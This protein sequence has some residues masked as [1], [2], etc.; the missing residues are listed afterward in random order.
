MKKISVLMAT[1]F[2]DMIGFAI[3]FPILPFYA[4]RFDAPEWMI[5]PLLASFSVMQLIASPLWGR[6]SD[7]FGRR[8]AI[9]LGLCTSAIAFLIF[10]FAVNLLMLFATRLVQGIGGGTTGVAQAYVGDS[11]DPKDRAKALGWL[12]AAT[13]AGV[14][15]GPAIGSYAFRLG[16]Q[17]PGL[18]ASGLCLLNVIF[19]WFWLPESTP[20][21]EEEDANSSAPPKERRAVKAMMLEVLFTP[22]GD[23]PRLIWIYTAGML[24]FMS[25]AAILPLYLGA[26][27]GITEGNI[28]PFFVYTG[29]LSIVMRAVVLGKLVDLFGETRVMRAGALLL[30]TGLFSLPLSTT[31][32]GTVAMMSFI[33]MG[34]ALLFPNVSALVSHRAPRGEL[35]QV[36]GV[37][38][39]FGG[40]ARVLGP[41]WATLVFD[42][43]GITAPFFVASGIVGLVTVLAFRVKHRDT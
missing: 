41:V 2:V 14:M 32:L 19:A 37:Q 10:G 15:M 17:Y 18:I 5:G 22:R 11:I 27:F 16:P 6:F 21:K 33:P 34:T 43:V 4:L 7:K 1:A 24:G 23:V 8:P 20:K 40:M 35:G 38:Q 36:M 9:I 31:I 3:V 39:S 26:R 29:F 28:G 25:M 12:S 42:R 13:S 30:A